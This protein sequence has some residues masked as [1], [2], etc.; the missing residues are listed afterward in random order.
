MKLIVFVCFLVVLTPVA[1]QN[2]G[3]E[4]KH[5]GAGIIIGGIGGYSAHKLFNG[6]RGWTWAGAVGSSLAAGLAK[7]TFYDKPRGAQWE[8][9][10]VLYTALG[11][12]LSGLALD[13]IYKNNRRRGGRGKKCGCLVA[14]SD[15]EHPI[16]FS[17]YNSNSSGNISSELQVAYF[18]R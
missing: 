1:G 16:E 15:F 2:I 6:Q 8:S 17:L 3:N 4:A 13:L 18:L 11:G 9:K 14:Q 5:V 12:I 7:E 10:D